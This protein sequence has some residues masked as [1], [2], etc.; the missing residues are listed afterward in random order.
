[1]KNPMIILNTS[2]LTLLSTEDVKYPI[3][4]MIQ[5]DY[6]KHYVKKVS[7]LLQNMIKI[8]VLMWVKCSPSIQI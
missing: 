2:S 5:T 8:Y 3:M 4:V 7:V 6:I 1:M